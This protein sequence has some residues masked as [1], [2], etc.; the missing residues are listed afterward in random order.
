MHAASFEQL[1]Q[2]GDAQRRFLQNCSGAVVCQPRELVEL[3][4]VNRGPPVNF[5]PAIE[6]ASD[7]ATQ[8]AYVFTAPGVGIRRNFI[9]IHHYNIVN[10]LEELIGLQA[11]MPARPERA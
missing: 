3:D 9:I 5:T 4:V 7:G 8:T 10:G 11:H 6:W 1:R 2:S